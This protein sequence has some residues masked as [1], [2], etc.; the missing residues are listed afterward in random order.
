ME[1]WKTFVKRRGEEG[2]FRIEN[3]L[4][5]GQTRFQFIEVLDTTP[6]GLSLFLDEKLQSAELDEFIYHE[7]LV[8]PSL[9]THPNPQTVLIAGGAEGATLR[10]VLKHSTVRRAVMVDIDEEAVRICQEYLPSWSKGAFQDRRVELLHLDARRYLEDTREVF[11]VII[12]DV[13]DPIAGGP[14]CLLF[15]KEFYQLAYDRLGDDGLL[16]TQ[17][18][19]INLNDLDYYLAIVNTLRSVFPIIFPYQAGIPS[20]GE[21][22]GFVSASKR[23]NPAD[24]TKEMTDHILQERRCLD[25]RYYD[26]LTHYSLSFLPKYLRQ[27]L[28]ECQ[29]IITNQN[30]LVI[31]D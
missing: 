27:K 8:H 22:W 29:H 16:A 1:K 4:Y 13:T 6:Y 14:S 30:P 31:A 10:E 3:V 18:E 20:Y 7:A 12:V 26:G 25:L 17:A 24:L 11:D 5:G 19:C 15:T 21:T 23:Y 2:R 28:Q 9:V